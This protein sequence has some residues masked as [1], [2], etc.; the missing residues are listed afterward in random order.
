MKQPP[1]HDIRSGAL[2]GLIAG[3]LLAVWATVVL[4]THGGAAFESKHLTYGTTVAIYLAGGTI[5]G[6]IVGAL[7]PLARYD[8]GVPVVGIAAALPAL[9]GLRIATRGIGRW[10]AFDAAFVGFG[11]LLFG[12][13]GALI[14][15]GGRDASKSKGQ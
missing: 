10:S 14:Y 9:V 7:K 6:A 11:A 8:V 13:C 15:L 3:G 12:L 1:G 4:V 5:S 2:A